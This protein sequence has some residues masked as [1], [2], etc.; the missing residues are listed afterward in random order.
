EERVAVLGGDGVE[1]ATRLREA[2]PRTAGAPRI[3]F[4]FGGQGSQVAGMGRELYETEPVFR[5]AVL[6]C[7]EIL[8]QATGQSIVPVLFPEAAEAALLT[9]TSLLQQALFVLEHA[10]SRLWAEWG[11]EPD[12][13]VGHSLGEYVAACT[14]GVMGLEDALR[15][16]AA[17][18][19]LMGA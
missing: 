14:A 16:V 10:L 11:I 3:A 4:L 9:E 15:L 17:R 5:A 8:R 18:G 2:R 6:E 12:A 19:R 1:I 13:V 7:D